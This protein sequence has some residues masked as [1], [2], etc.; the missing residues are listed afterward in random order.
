MNEKRFIPIKHSMGGR[1]GHLALVNFL[2]L[3]FSDQGSVYKGCI[4][5]EKPKIIGETE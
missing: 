3:V 1:N 5:V 4:M 2:R